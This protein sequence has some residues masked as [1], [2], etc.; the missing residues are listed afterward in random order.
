MKNIFYINWYSFFIAF[1]F[2]IIYVYF[3]TQNDKHMMFENVNNNIYI[4]DN[5]ECYK[6]DVINIKCLDDNNY[7][8][9]LI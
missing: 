3:I 7:P 8:T 4:G 9:P 1:I 2:G 5:N 6:Y